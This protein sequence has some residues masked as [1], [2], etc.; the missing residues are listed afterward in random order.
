[1]LKK[2]LWESPSTPTLAYHEMFSAE[3]ETL[4]AKNDKFS[5]KTEKFLANVSE[6]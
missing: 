2:R 6:F 3:T 1:V 4:P 5:A